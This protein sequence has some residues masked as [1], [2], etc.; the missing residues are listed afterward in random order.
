MKERAGRTPLTNNDGNAIQNKT[1]NSLPKYN[2]AHQN[3][4][5]RAKLPG[6]LDETI[7]WT[8]NWSANPHEIIEGVSKDWRG[9]SK[10]FTDRGHE[11]LMLLSDGYKE[12]VEQ[13]MK[14]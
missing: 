11:M 10:F 7:L 6:R 2:T 4:S 9:G 14:N 8:F 13:L 12:R 5:W 3:V 1:V